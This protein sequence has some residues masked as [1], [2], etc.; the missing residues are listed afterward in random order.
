MT[1]LLWFYGVVVALALLTPL[2]APGASIVAVA[3]LAAVI[4]VIIGRIFP[5]EGSDAYANVLVGTLP[6][7]RRQ[8]VLARFLAALLLVLATACVVAVIL[9]GSSGLERLSMVVAFALAPLL[10]LAIAG[11]MACS[12]RFG[13]MG[14]MVPRLPL[15][16]IFVVVM[17][18]PQAWQQH[19]VSYVLARPAMS[20]AVA[21]AALLLALLISLVLSIRWFD[22]RDL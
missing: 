22:R 2:L 4:V 6:V 17:L 11:P 8:V 20:A 5:F 9:A 7:S 15:L 3:M 12:G 1:S 21:G 13:P 18:A 19:A 16:A 10:S 14:A